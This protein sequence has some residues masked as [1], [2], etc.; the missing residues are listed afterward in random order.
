MTVTQYRLDVDHTCGMK[1]ARVARIAH[2]RGWYHDHHASVYTL[3]VSVGGGVLKIQQE[4]RTRK[5]VKAVEELT[6]VSAAMQPNQQVLYVTERAVFGLR[7][8]KLALLEVAP[9]VDVQR[10]VLDVMDFVPSMQD[11]KRMDASLFQ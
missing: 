6:F 5:F 10:H 3:Q 11:V 8:G 9:G 2:Q 4:G 1:I 7:D